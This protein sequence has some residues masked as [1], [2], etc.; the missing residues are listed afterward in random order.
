MSGG[1]AH[2]ET[3]VHEDVREKSL[4]RRHNE[5]FTRIVVDKWTER[6]PYDWRKV[7]AIYMYLL[8]SFFL[9]FVPTYL[10]AMRLFLYKVCGVGPVLRTIT[11]TLQNG[12]SG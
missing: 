6:Y 3:A 1:G 10:C 11:M 8:H 5:S 7:K 9:I 12:L 2:K 4:Y